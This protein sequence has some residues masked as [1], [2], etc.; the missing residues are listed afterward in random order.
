MPS[1]NPPDALPVPQQLLVHLREGRLVLFAGAGLSAQAGLP[2]WGSLLK[3]VVEATLA[4]TVP[5]PGTRAELE[6]MIAAGKWL[7]IADHCKDQ[8]GP[9]GYARLMAERLGDTG[10]AVPEA[11]RLAVQLPFAAW[12]TTNYDKL[13][14]RAYAEVRGGLPKTLTCL[15]TE[16]LGRLLFDGAP[17]VLKAHGD[18]DKPDSLVFTSRDYRD[19]IHGNAAFSAAFSA[20]LLTHSVLFVGYSLADPD[21]NLLLDRQLLTFR[22]F[23][24]E[25]YALM[26]GIGKVE[27][28]YLRRA[29]QIRVIPY[30]EGRHESVPRFFGQLDQ[31]LQQMGAAPPRAAPARGAPRF[32]SA[33]AIARTVA[34]GLAASF[35][36]PSRTG[37][38]ARTA[39]AQADALVLE[40]DWRDDAVHA[41]L[42]DGAAVLASTTGPRDDWATLAQAARALEEGGVRAGAIATC[43]DALARSVGPAA[44]KA[45][46]KA[47]KAHPAR[48]LRLQLTRAAERLPWE[49]LALGGRTLVEA[50]AVYR[51]PVGVSAD[52]RGLPA[53]G[54]PLRA[55]LI[56]DTRD[57]EPALALPGA[58][59]EAHAIAEELGR[60]GADIELL[61]GVRATYDAVDEAL[62]R[63]D[64]D[65]VHFAGHAWFDDH[66]A[67]LELADCRL[68]ATMA[69]PWLTRRPPA[70]MFLNS[71]Y[72]AFIPAG[73]ARPIGQHA[74]T[75]HAGLG[76]RHGF[77]DLAMRSGTGA[78][79]GTFSGAIDDLGARD[80]AV[81]VY[82]ALLGGATA[83]AAV[84]GA[85][86]AAPATGRET[87]LMYCLY[88][89]GALRLTG[90]GAGT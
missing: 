50:A 55:L 5:G 19:L 58:A 29:C 39:A 84:H 46:Q 38:V 52:A 83:A 32:A 34:A 85:R 86:V 15:D 11:H 89:E 2:T 79:L 47:L 44:L 67:F 7:Q 16:A 31:R 27:E 18:L 51:A 69:R 8:L 14:E 56:A 1:E 37:A 48:P 78:F 53:V 40:L 3:D 20:I 80:F 87:A 65:I 88:G 77:S 73:V 4:E 6:G 42:G 76:G 13:L 17:F 68:T 81:A 75:I 70:F 10:L 45:W 24:P 25:R 66:E 12:V 21:F 61:L 43:G 57:R 36:K 74:S 35:A 9:G 54:A 62:D 64:P 33:P 30:P 72:T 90:T 71:H 49:L 23:V 26:S 41:A 60:Q 59:A 28:E 82:R 63:L 22:G